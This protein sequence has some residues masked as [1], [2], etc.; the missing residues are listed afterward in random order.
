MFTLLILISISPATLYAQ[1]CT[2]YTSYNTSCALPGA[3]GGTK[4]VVCTD[5]PTSASYNDFTKG[6]GSGAIDKI[7]DTNDHSGNVRLRMVDSDAGGNI[8]NQTGFTSLY[9]DAINGSVLTGT[10]TLTGVSRVKFENITINELTL[11]GATN[12]EFVNCTIRTLNITASSNCNTFTTCT[13]GATG[14]ATISGGSNKNT[15]TNCTI[16]RNTGNTLSISGGSNDNNFL[17]GT[18]GKIINT[19]ATGTAVFIDNSGTGNTGNTF[20]GLTIGGES[21]SANRCQYAIR[22]VGGTGTSTA[23]VTSCKIVNY[24]SA[25]SESAGIYLGTGNTGWTITGNKFYLETTATADVTGAGLTDGWHTP[26]RIESGSGYTITSNNIGSNSDGGTGIYTIALTGTAI[27]THI[28]IFTGIYIAGNAGATNLGDITSNTISNISFQTRSP[29]SSAATGAN[30]SDVGAFAGISVGAHDE[31]TGSGSNGNI[32]INGNTIGSTSIESQGGEFVGIVSTLTGTVNIGNTIK[33][34][35]TGITVTNNGSNGDNAFMGIKAIGNNATQLIQ[36]NDINNITLGTTSNV[37]RALIAG[38][39]VDGTGSTNTVS[40]NIISTINGRGVPTT[41]L[42]NTSAIIQLYASTTCIGNQITSIT[43]VSKLGFSNTSKFLINGTL[44]TLIG[45]YCAAATTNSID[46]N[47]IT[48]LI[49]EA[50]SS[51]ALSTNTADPVYVAG[52]FSESG[53]TT[54]ISRSTISGLKNNSTDANAGIYGIIAANGSTTVSNNT[55]INMANTDNALSAGIVLGT[56]AATASTDVI[57]CTGN[58]ITNVNSNKASGSIATVDGSR[59]VATGIYC[60]AIGATGAGSTLIENNTI[61]S[62]TSNASAA[63]TGIYTSTTASI[64]RNTIYG[65]S[66]TSGAASAIAG[67]AAAGGTTTAHNNMISLSSLAS[68]QLHGIW[69]SNPSTSLIRFN[70]V[71]LSGA[72]GNTSACITQTGGGTAT[73]ENNLL[74]NNLS[75]GTARR[76]ITGVTGENYNVLIGNTGVTL[77]KVGAFSYSGTPTTPTLPIES[78][79]PSDPAKLFTNFATADL[80][81]KTD[82]STQYTDAAGTTSSYA[83]LVSGKGNFIT[84]IST[85]KGGDAR[86]TTTAGGPTDIGADEFASPSQL[87]P[88]TALIASGGTSN[89]IY[90]NRT[91]A[92]IAWA[93]TGGITGT[94]MRFY[95]GVNHPNGGGLGGAHTHSYWEVD[96]LGT[97]NTDLSYSITL[98]SGAHEAGSSP[99]TSFVN[100]FNALGWFRTATAGNTSGQFAGFSSFVLGPG[101]TPTPVELTSFKAQTRGSQVDLDWVTGSELINEGFEV[102]RSKNGHDFEPLAFIEGAGTTDIAQYYSYTD[103]NPLVG[104]SYYRLKQLDTGGAFAYSRVEKVARELNT[105]TKQMV[106]YPNPSSGDLFV[107]FHNLATKGRLMVMDLTGREINAQELKESSGTVRINKTLNPGAYL[108]RYLSAIGE[109]ITQ[110]VIVK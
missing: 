4:V 9:I 74:W 93:N 75:A 110:K 20:T 104:I 109:V 31:S 102:Q 57:N 95:S 40:N 86:S 62:G 55:A 66:N 53:N 58:T 73:V 27:D 5:A 45:I 106:A 67:I 105:E 72:A 92:S 18:I 81:I 22:S 32:N 13:I 29:K 59:L 83:W 24:F 37:G 28:P 70:S 108:I 78:D 97:A 19:S 30:E 48:D 35:I 1:T 91:M 107:E 79:I 99:V 87:P 94:R 16:S 101:T 61:S 41:L 56:S 6:N 14:G 63:I 33:N 64:L 38:I 23:T 49:H 54:T 10:T 90:N 82:A 100:K 89:Y 50:N 36:S 98:N 34:T 80:T 96:A 7:Q 26:I 8:N 11:V 44:P 21:A 43:E 69:L 65:L 51:G 71:Y 84:G 42:T 77:N 52:I 3:G 68:N 60:Q 46:N 17:V 76:T 25:T 85:D 15:F 12:C 88:A 47:I 39:Y 103:K 2:A